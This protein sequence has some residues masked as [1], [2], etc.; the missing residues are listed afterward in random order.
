MKTVISTTDAARHL[1]DYLARVRF[2]NEH[3]LLT[4]N[5]KPVA[6]LSPAIGSNAATWGECC[7]AVKGLPL[8]PA[9]ADDLEAVNRSDKTLDNPWD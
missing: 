6:E 7:R 2:R 3:F 1:G 8:D 4:K 9:F 5:E